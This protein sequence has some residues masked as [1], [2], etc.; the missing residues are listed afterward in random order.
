M[1]RL[2]KAFIFFLLL[3][4]LFY[5]PTKIVRGD[6]C[7]ACT[8]ESDCNARISCLT[9]Q[10]TSLSSQIELITTKIKVTQSQIDTTQAK[11]YRLTDDIASVSGKINTIQGSL[12]HVSEVLANRISATYMQGRSDPMLYLISAVNFTDFF[13]R[14]DYLRLAR[15]H[16]EELMLQMAG[17]KKNYNDQKALFEDK[18]RQVEQL[19]AQ[20]QAFKVQ[21]KQQNKD[22]QALLA[23]TQ[24][25]LNQAI[26]ELAAFQSFVQSQGGAGLISPQTKCDDWGCYYNQR[27]STWGAMA[28]NHTGYTLADSGCLVTSMAMAISHFR[29]NGDVTPVTI[30]SNSSNFAVYY[31]A[32]LNLSIS[33]GGNWTRVRIS[34]SQADDELRNGRPVV[35]G[36]GY[37]PAHF[38]VWVSGS[39]GNYQ[40]NDPYFEN[41]KNISFASKY[42]MGQVTEIDAVQAN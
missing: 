4:V 22:K 37:G 38:V 32:F 11:I 18:K 1:G 12:Q 25:Q 10:K 23:T 8:S 36:I 29:H 27:D 35:V 42:S 6:D 5:L 26:A 28:L 24:E 19:S 34:Q 14:F 21:L 3:G 41:G 30:N 17:T 9:A 31:P 13:R 7:S 20:L 2:T 33:A 15:K 39:N 16:D 40:M